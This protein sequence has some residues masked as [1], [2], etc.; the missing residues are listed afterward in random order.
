MHESGGALVLL[1]LC[2][3]PG[4]NFVMHRHIIE[5]IGGWDPDALSEDTEIS[6]RIYRM[7]Y[8][9]KLVPQAVTGSRS[10]FA[11]EFGSSSVPAGRWGTCMC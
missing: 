7:G 1:G 9:I 6:F 11:W 8:K 3:I 4:T 5:E 10:R 2:T